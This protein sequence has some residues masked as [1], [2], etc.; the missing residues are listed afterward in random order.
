MDASSGTASSRATKEAHASSPVPKRQLVPLGFLRKG[1]LVNFSLRNES[2]TSLPLLNS[3]QNAQISEALLI[4]I[5]TRALAGPVPQEIRCDIRDLVRA[6]HS[7]SKR[8]T[9]AQIAH[10]RLFG[11]RDKALTKRE[12]L[13]NH[14]AFSSTAVTFIKYFLALSVLDIYRHQRRVIRFSY[15]EP[16]H[17]VIGGGARSL[18]PYVQ[19]LAFGEPRVMAVGAPAVGQAH[20]YHLEVESPEGHMISKR[21]SYRFDVGNPIPV[22]TRS[23]GTYRR[24]HFHLSHLKPGSKAAALV[25]LR[26]RPYTIVRG[27]TGTC[28]LAFLTIA[29]VA[30]RLGEIEH[31]KGEIATAVLLS[32]AGLMSLFVV[33]SGEQDIATTLL[34][35]LRTLVTAPVALS[36]GAALVVL[37]QPGLRAG[38]ILLGFFGFLTGIVTLMLARNWWTI[39]KAMRTYEHVT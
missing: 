25:Y 8:P 31:G 13:N 29:T 1:V 16:L 5:A 11:T 27:A 35:P 33:R 28:I 22:P 23:T 2:D 4:S 6:D 15:E 34:F 32:F 9:P 30:M 37:A 26:P 10:S 36:F 39:S 24:A 38:Q 12:L 3:A 7:G 19:R 14:E 21:E 18:F 20:S 17:E